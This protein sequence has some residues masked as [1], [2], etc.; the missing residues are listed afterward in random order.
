MKRILFSLVLVVTMLFN[1]VAFAQINAYCQTDGT[2][3]LFV[4]EIFRWKNMKD[5]VYTAFDIQRTFAKDKEYT[6]LRVT[7]EGSLKEKN[8]LKSV[9]LIIDKEKTLNMQ[10]VVNVRRDNMPSGTEQKWYGFSDGDLNAIISGKNCEVEIETTSGKIL[11]EKLKPQSVNDLSQMLTL[12]RENWRLS[13]IDYYAQP[14]YQL[15]IPGV[16]SKQ[17]ADAVAY[18]AN[19][20]EKDKIV[21]YGGYYRVAVND[22]GK[23]MFIRHDSTD[24][25]YFEMEDG[26]NGCWLNASWLRFGVTGSASDI[27]NS[28]HK[29]FAPFKYQRAW[30]MLK[31]NK[32]YG[33]LAGKYNYGM[34]VRSDKVLKSALGSRN[35]QYSKGPFVIYSLNKEVFPQL[36]EI[37]AGDTIVSINGIDTS[38]MYLANFDKMTE[39]ADDDQ[40][41]IF[42]IKKSDG[43]ENK[44]KIVPMF[45]K[46]RQIVPDYVESNKKVSFQYLRSAPE[47]W[48]PYEVFDSFAPYSD[49]CLAKKQW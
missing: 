1:G 49:R 11:N 37:N 13:K 10:E 20:D 7:L 18:Y 32:M 30:W 2:D 41:I 40:E 24:M 22:S 46:S 35:A 9:K 16:T 36:A 28:D 44:I 12:K 29:D 6:L 5:R 8:D 39:Y 48:S 14:T 23:T 25:I 42:G 3:T 15:F 4:R 43:Q 45:E 19:R 34:G 27:V 17:A 31:F 33:V 47:K 21:A 38:D 26:K